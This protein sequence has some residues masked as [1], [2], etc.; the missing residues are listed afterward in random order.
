MSIAF[1]AVFCG[2]VCPF[3]TFQEWLGKIG[4]ILFKKKYD[5]VIPHNIDRVLRYFR[6]I[7]A[8]WIIYITA[9]SG[10]LIFGDY[11][12][13]YALFNF[14]SDEVAVQALVILGFIVLASLIAERPWCKYA[15]P[16]GALT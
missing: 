7:V 4:R 16:L 13:Y 6:Y 9:V 15:C 2:W 14:W 1:G 12:P 11:D 10:K 8:A 5:N 3:G